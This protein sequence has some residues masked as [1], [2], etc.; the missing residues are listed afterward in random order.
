M[1]ELRKN[2]DEQMRK[3]KEDLLVSQQLIQSNITMLSSATEQMSKMT[4]EQF[5]NI[6]NTFLGL[7]D[8]M[9]SLK[10]DMERLGDKLD[11]VKSVQESLASSSEKLAN[12]FVDAEIKQVLTEII[13]QMLYENQPTT[14]TTTA[15]TAAT[16]S[17]GAS[18]E[19]PPPP[20]P[21]QPPSSS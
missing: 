13:D 10:N 11:G 21:P 3:A 14:T 20:Q 7:F 6:G 4:N 17:S 18:N 8:K 16:S 1:E 15:T 9:N 12:Y 5:A 19:P 2:Y